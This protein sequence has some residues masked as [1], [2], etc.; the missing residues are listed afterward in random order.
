VAVRRLSIV[1]GL[2]AVVGLLG[3]AAAQEAEEIPD[4]TGK[5]MKL[6]RDHDTIE[7]GVEEDSVQYFTVDE[8]SVPGWYINHRVG[9]VVALTLQ[10]QGEKGT[11]VVAIRH[12]SDGD[13][14]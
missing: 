14:D 5:I 3:Q 1:V 6:D 11:R 13:S 7:L 2:L 12:V 9:E 4:V 10:A 8:D